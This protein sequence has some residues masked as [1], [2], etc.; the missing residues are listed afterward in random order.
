MLYFAF[1]YLH[2]LYETEIYVNTYL[3]YLHKL[4]TSNNKIIQILLNRPTRTHTTDLYRHYNTLPL[5]SLHNYQILFF[6]HKF[7]Y[8]PDKIQPVYIKFYIQLV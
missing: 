7:L 6:V 3:S 4:E 2:L 5:P 1:L 8:H